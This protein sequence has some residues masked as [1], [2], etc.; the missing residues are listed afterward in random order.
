MDG[1]NTRFDIYASGFNLCRIYAPDQNVRK[2][3]TTIGNVNWCNASP[4]GSSWPIPTAEAAAFP[5][6][7]NMIK[8]ADLSFDTDVSVGDGAWNCAAYWATAHSIGA[9]ANLPPPGCTASAT[10]SRYDVYRYELSFVNDR[11]RGAEYGAPRCA[12]PG[13]ANRRIIT[14]AIVN[15]GSSPVPVLNDAQNVPVASFGRFF[16]VLPAI[17]SAY[18]NTYT[19]GNPYAEFVGLV[20]RN[21]PQSTDMVQLNR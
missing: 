1:L 7:A 10:I 2:G 18:G 20:K 5:V 21:D 16:L 11:S 17:Q 14:A 13:A 12:P 8:P 19:N 15:C 4:A 9:G 6:D 3:F